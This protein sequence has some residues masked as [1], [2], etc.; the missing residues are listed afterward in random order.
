[1]ILILCSVLHTFTS[2][3]PHI[4][5]P[6]PGLGKLM[7]G[8]NETKPTFESEKSIKSSPISSSPGLRKP[9]GLNGKM[10]EKHNTSTNAA[11]NSQALKTMTTTPLISKIKIPD[12]AVV[13][14]PLN[15]ILQVCVT[16]V[17]HSQRCYAYLK[18]RHTLFMDLILRTGRE[19]QHSTAT[20]PELGKICLAQFEGEW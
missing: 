16:H 15:T 8:P 9:H 2:G 5:V 10:D 1:M 6:Q 18:S 20:T 4:I 7:K 14:I 3:K 11:G 19:A 12:Y 17:L 13:E